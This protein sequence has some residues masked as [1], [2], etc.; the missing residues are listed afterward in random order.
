MEKYI[1]V[2]YHTVYCESTI[3]PRKL[4]WKRKANNAIRQ[5]HMEQFTVRVT[6][7]PEFARFRVVHFHIMAARIWNAAKTPHE[8]TEASAAVRV[9]VTTLGQTLGHICI[10]CGLIVSD[11]DIHAV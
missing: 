9:L 4:T 11:S 8:T 3:T 2:N 1:L 10:H 6:G 7:N 5:Y